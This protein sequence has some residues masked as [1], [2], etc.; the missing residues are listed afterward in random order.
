MSACSTYN[1]TAILILIITG[2]S[3]PP[4]LTGNI[5]S[6]RSQ[7]SSSQR[8]S[9]DSSQ[10]NRYVVC[11][12]VELVMN[13]IPC[14]RVYSD[15]QLHADFTN[16]QDASQPMAHRKTRLSKTL[17]GLSSQLSVDDDDDEDNV[18]MKDLVSP[19]R[20]KASSPSNLRLQ[21]S[22]PKP[23]SNPSTPQRKISY[24]AAVQNG[25]LV[26]PQTLAPL[27]MLAEESLADSVFTHQGLPFTRRQSDPPHQ[28][29]LIRSYT[30]RLLYQRQPQ[31]E[32]RLRTRWSTD[33]TPFPPTEIIGPS[34]STAN[35][36]NFSSPLQ[37]S[38]K[39]ESHL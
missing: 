33:N 18:S 35:W 19:L 26:S 29:E 22:S 23:R 3:G 5:R 32:A 2:T 4:D 9:W 25:E 34:S 20:P 31:S 37:Q 1:V 27:D 14:S 6:K 15:D 17:G 21:F 39:Q 8:K 38:N 24:V 16:S 30:G 10:F 28:E 7:G 13:T 36:S 11:A 12:I